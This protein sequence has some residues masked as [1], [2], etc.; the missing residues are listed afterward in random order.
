[1]ERLEG[2]LDLKAIEQKIHSRMKTCSEAMGKEL[3]EAVQEVNDV[4]RNWPYF[5]GTTTTRRSPNAKM[6]V[7][8]G[9]YRD[10]VDSGEASKAISVQSE[11]MK[12]T[13]QY[14]GLEDTKEQEM[15]TAKPVLEVAMSEFDF[16]RSFRDNF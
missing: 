14:I 9:V 12:H 6:K 16:A 11:D 5:D 2:M 1:L 4:A 15:L 3:G 8:Q 10:N 7:V 13:V